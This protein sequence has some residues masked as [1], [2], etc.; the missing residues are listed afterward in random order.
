MRIKK[1]EFK[2][3]ASVHNLQVVGELLCSLEMLNV[4]QSVVPS[5]RDLGTSFRRLQVLWISRSGL[6]DLGGLV[7]F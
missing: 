1:I 6:K 4:S 5:I 2:I 7:A 3:N